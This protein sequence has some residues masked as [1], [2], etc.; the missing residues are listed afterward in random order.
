MLFNFTKARDSNTDVFYYWGVKDINREG[1]SMWVP[2]FV[3]EVILDPEFS[4]SCQECQ[5]VFKDFCPDL[6]EAGFI[7]K[8][9]AS[10]WFTD[11]EAYLT[12]SNLKLPLE[13]KLFNT[14]LLKWASS[15][16]EGKLAK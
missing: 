1:D 3:G 10:C 9:S 16:D 2:G 15:T 14:N 6:I 11:F 5:I 4:I 12:K 8:D 13:E 7:V